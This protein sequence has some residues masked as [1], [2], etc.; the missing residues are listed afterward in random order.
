MRRKGSFFRYILADAILFALIVAGLHFSLAIFDLKFR[1]WFY[2]AAIFLTV[3][4]VIA[5]VMQLLLK[6]RKR[7]LKI[8]L[9]IIWVCLAGAFT[10]IL[11]GGLMFACDKEYKVERDGTE[12]LACEWSFLKTGISYYEY[13]NFIVAGNVLRISE[14]YDLGADIPLSTVYY[15]ENGVIIEEIEAVGNP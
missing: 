8:I 7:A 14:T 10:L 5:G 15:D 11:T 1:Q 9:I 6:I 2:L 12:Y 13:K 3:F 4:G